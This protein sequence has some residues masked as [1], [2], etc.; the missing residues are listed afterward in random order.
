MYSEEAHARSG[1]YIQ[2]RKI[3]RKQIF[4][5]AAIAAVMLAASGCIREDAVKFH[6]IS[7]IDIA[8]SLN[9]R[10]EATME[11]ENTSGRNITIKDILF[12][13]TDTDGNVIGTLKVNKDL[14]IPKRSRIALT[15]KKV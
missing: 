4:Y 8:I 7:D 10:L 3:M 15:I 12:D 5:I 14:F 9:P 2:R 13:V 1:I 11:V 6:G